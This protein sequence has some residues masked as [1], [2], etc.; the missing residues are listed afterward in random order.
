MLDDV[1]GMAGF[2]ATRHGRRTAVA[3][4]RRLR[5]FWPDLRG[6][7][8]L[9]LG[10]AAPFLMP[11]R[12][13]TSHC[14]DAVCGTASRNRASCLVQDDQL[15]FPDGL[16]DRILLVHLVEHA[17]N[18]TRT[19]RAVQR[20]LRDD[21]RLLLVVPNRTGLLAHSERTPFGEGAPFS[22]GRIS[23]T[24]ARSL[25]RVERIEGALFLPPVGIRGATLVAAAVD[26]LGHRATPGL[27]GVLI[28]EAVKDIHAAL[29]VPAAATGRQLVRR[30]LPV[31]AR[32]QAGRLTTP[33]ERL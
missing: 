23:R 7:R 21:G 4:G 32:L 28:V 1:Q 27:S 31:P 9:G 25:F 30:L 11:W 17:A 15:P 19:L 24:L 2:Y 14:V 13:H 6:Q 16:F 3:V 20:V 22:S 33:D 10:Y 18:V 29:P 26:R 8:L 12:R 5:A